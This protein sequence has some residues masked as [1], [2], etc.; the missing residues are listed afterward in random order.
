MAAGRA[1]SPSVRRGVNYLLENQD[2]DGLWREPWFTA[3][4][5]PRVFYLKYHGYSAYFPV[6]ALARYRNLMEGEG[7]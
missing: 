2:E 4:G 5:F 3:A 6:L 1:F 7:K